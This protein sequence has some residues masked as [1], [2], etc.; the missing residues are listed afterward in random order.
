[1]DPVNKVHH[2]PAITN[3]SYSDWLGVTWQ[4][5]AEQT[6]EKLTSLKPNWLIVDHY[7]LDSNW[8]KEVRPLV[9]R[10]MVIDDL[11]NRSH[12]CAM[13]LDQNLG[14]V[15]SDYEGLSSPNCTKLIGPVF[16]LLRPEFPASR[17]RSLLRRR[18]AGLSRI[19][20]SLG[21]ADQANVTSQVLRVL[22]MS[23][24]P[25]A[26]ELD[27]VMGASAPSLKEVCDLAARLPFKAT[28]STDVADMAER[29]CQADL[30]I[31]AAGGTS[32]ERCCLGL[33]VVLVTLAENQLSGAR[34]LEA[35][36]A[37][38]SVGWPE[39]LSKELPLAIAK[40]KEPEALQRMSRAAAGVTEG[41][42]VSKVFAAMMEISRGTG[43]LSI[44]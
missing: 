23:S 18:S 2:S 33:P 34:A 4:K 17:Q 3:V 24:L 30:S 20:V 42:G 12:D 7:A 21:G 38:V 11:A 28:V 6:V 1:M 10:I 29:M 8:H 15:L 26:T 31:G 25:D 41:D 5:D 13:L 22:A 16:A 40:V 39:A 44:N 14:R 43:C 35:A 36:G 27:I 37:A 9:D 32:W 19:L